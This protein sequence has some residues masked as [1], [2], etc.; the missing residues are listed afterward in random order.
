LG[1]GGAVKIKEMSELC[2]ITAD[3]L[4]Y[5]EKIGLIPPVKRTDGGVREYRESDTNWIEFIKCMRSA[6]L[7]IEVLLEYVQLFMQGEE[8][9]E[10]RK[11]LLREQRAQ[12]LA[13]M[14]EMQR[15]LDTLNHKIEV[16]E[17]VVLKKE[18]ELTK[19]ES[20]A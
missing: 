14:G 8:T 1:G 11:N 7:S 3:T 15:T 6:G 12:L 10:A 5:Y 19:K 17:N 9:V 4:R 2:G 18:Y 16:Y 13:K 20:G